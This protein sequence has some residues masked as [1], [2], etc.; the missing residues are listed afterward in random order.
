MGQMMSTFLEH[1]LKI[2]G[3][4]DLSCEEFRARDLPGQAKTISYP[5]SGVVETNTA[6]DWP[7]PDLPHLDDSSG[8]GGLSSG[9]SKTTPESIGSGQSQ[10]QGID[11]CVFGFGLTADASMR[12]E[13]EKAKKEGIKDAGDEMSVDQFFQEWE[14]AVTREKEGWSR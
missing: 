5:K 1:Y 13:A 10:D 14:G 11:P 2:D 7:I 8:S 6:F 3:A 4:S 9:S 12:F